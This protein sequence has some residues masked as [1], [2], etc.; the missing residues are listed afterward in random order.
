[1]IRAF[2][3]AIMQILFL[4]VLGNTVDSTMKLLIVI[5]QFLLICYQLSIKEVE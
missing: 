5:V 1:M 4:V 3:P 2:L